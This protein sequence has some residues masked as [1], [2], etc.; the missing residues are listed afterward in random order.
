MEEAQQ[1]LDLEFDAP[2][3]PF[4]SSCT[5]DSVVAI[6][7]DDPTVSAPRSDDIRLV[8]TLVLRS[9]DFSRTATRAAETVAEVMKNNPHITLQV[10][11]A[12][13]GQAEKIQAETIHEI[14]DGC[15]R[16]TSYLDRFY[17]LQPGHRMGAKRVFVLLPRS[18]R[19]NSRGEW[20]EAIGQYAGILWHA[21]ATPPKDY[22][23]YEHF[24]VYSPAAR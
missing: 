1:T 2:T 18:A 22:E 4:E 13:A 6:D 9:V 23:E 21:D 24:V 15:Y 16:T 10:V 3:V 19:P 12:A 8:T 5:A 7:L 17:S 11:L 20:T 14:L